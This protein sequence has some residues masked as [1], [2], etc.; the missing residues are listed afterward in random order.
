M[1]GEKNKRAKDMGGGQRKRAT[2][3]RAGLLLRCTCAWLVGAMVQSSVEAEKQFT[4]KMV[5]EK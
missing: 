3:D 5:Q 1:G 2:V 4:L